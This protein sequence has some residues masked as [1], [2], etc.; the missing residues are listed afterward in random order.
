MSEISEILEQF[1]NKRLNKDKIYADFGIASEV[2]LVNNTCTVTPVSGDAP[3]LGVKFFPISTSTAGLLLAP[4]NDSTVGYVYTS[5][6]DAFITLFGEVDDIIFQ[7]GTNEGLVKVVELTAKINDLENL[8]NDLISKYNAHIH[9]TT[10]TVGATTVPGVI[11]P[12][13]SLE[14]TIIAPITN[15]TEIQNDKF[16]H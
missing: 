12:T 11:A 16:K 8:L 6:T 7:G 1:V 5:P 9:I 10:A 15:K 14:T 2:E 3:R 4:A 13:T